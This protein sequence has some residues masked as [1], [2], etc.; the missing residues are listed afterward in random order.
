MFVVCDFELNAR[1]SKEF[2]AAFRTAFCVHYSTLLC[3][4][5]RKCSLMREAKIVYSG[6]GIVNGWRFAL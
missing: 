5:L 2:A 6:V 4:H 1:G 3:F